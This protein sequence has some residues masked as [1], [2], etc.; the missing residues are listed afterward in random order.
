MDLAF[1]DSHWSRHDLLTINRCCLAL[2]CL[3]VADIATGDGLYL[4]AYSFPPSALPSTYLWPKELPSRSD[5]KIWEQFLLSTICSGYHSLHQ[6][7]RPW[8]R[9]PHLYSSWGYC[10]VS[11]LTL[12]LPSS[13]KS[14]SVY[15]QRPLTPTCHSATPLDFSDMS[16]SLLTSARFIAIVSPIE[17]G[18]L[19]SGYALGPIST[20]TPDSWAAIIRDLGDTAWPITHLCPP[21]PP[22]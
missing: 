20:A 5:W 19:S 9:T 22:V 3:T 2:H 4:R 6:P 21:S 7:L 11:S 14:Y 1:A 10:D 18:V 15:A 8:L 16:F 12:Y 17:N 13:D